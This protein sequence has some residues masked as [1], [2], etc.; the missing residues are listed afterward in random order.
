MD[1]KAFFNH[2]GGS[3]ED[4]YSRFGNDAMIAYLVTKYGK[5]KT[6]DA[7]AAAV[8][9]GDINASF[10]AAHSL[11][12]VSG[13]MGF[14]R[15]FTCSCALTEQLRTLESEADS[16]LYREVCEAQKCILEAIKLY[17]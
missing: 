10:E 17:G 16:A 1:V 13:N 6:F 4:V 7:L 3:Y 2:I 5:D 14:E 11:K 9:A 8:S 12:G 15:L